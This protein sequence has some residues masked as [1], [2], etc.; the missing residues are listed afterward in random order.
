MV[1]VVTDDDDKR[2]VCERA[3]V[4][5]RKMPTAHGAM[6]VAECARFTTRAEFQL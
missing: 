6:V 4:R 5:Q 3:C 1:C 2:R